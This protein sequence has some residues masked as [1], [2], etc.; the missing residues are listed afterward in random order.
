MLIGLIY[1]M[2]IHLIGNHISIVLL[3]KISNQLQFLTGEHLTA[4]IGR[5]AQDQCLGILLKGRFQLFRVKMKFRRIKRH[6][7]RLC[8]GQNRICSIIFI[9]RRKDNDLISRIRYRHH[10]GHHCFRAATGNNNL[11]VRVNRS[12][13]EL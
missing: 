5:I 8:S 7:N 6:I 1:N 3:C 11:S 2:L 10:S 12:S 4:G 13:H 9:K